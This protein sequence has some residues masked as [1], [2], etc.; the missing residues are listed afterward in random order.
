MKFTARLFM[1][2]PT[3]TLSPSTTSTIS[4]VSFVINNLDGDKKISFDCLIFYTKI[5][6]ISITNNFF[7][8]VKHTQQISFPSKIQTATHAYEY[9]PK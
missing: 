8:L 3:V 4:H 5:P 7:P 6:Q 2:F 1:R 9:N